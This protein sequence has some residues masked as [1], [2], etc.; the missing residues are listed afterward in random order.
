MTKYVVEMLT[1]NRYG[2]LEDKAIVIRAESAD[3]ARAIAEA[4][5][6]NAAIGYVGAD[7]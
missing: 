3:A 7:L 6:P 2:G 1:T 5:Y 4:K